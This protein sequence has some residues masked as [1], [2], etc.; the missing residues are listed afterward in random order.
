MS[1]EYTKL[2]RQVPKVVAFA[3]GDVTGAPATTS[4]FYS[5]PPTGALFEKPVIFTIRFHAFLILPI[6]P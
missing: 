4:R 3:R 1:K 6:V 5:F 2:S